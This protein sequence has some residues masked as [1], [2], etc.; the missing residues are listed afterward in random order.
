MRDDFK[1]KGVAPDDRLRIRDKYYG[2]TFGRQGLFF[3]V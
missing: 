3:M 2:L 1:P